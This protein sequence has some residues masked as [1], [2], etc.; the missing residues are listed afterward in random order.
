MEKGNTK[1]AS[2]KQFLKSCSSQKTRELSYENLFRIINNCLTLRR[3]HIL[4]TK[5]FNH[6]PFD[7]FYP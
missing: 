4:K 7:G 3:N 2:E 1:S 5:K 6:I